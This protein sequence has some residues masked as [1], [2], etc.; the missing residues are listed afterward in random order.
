LT[1]KCFIVMLFGKPIEWIEQYKANVATLRKYGFEWLILTDVE[2][3]KAKVRKALG[4]D[5]CLDPNSTKYWDYRPFLGL[6]LAD[7]LRGFDFWGHTD[8]DVIYGRLDRWVTD[9]L[10]GSVDVFSNDPNACCGFFTLYRNNGV[11]N[12]LCLELNGGAWGQ[13]LETDQVFVSDEVGMT[14]VVRRAW[15]EGRIAWAS[16]F[17][18]GNDTN[19]VG[20]LRMEKDG[21][22]IWNGDEI[23]AY[24]F[25]RTKRWAL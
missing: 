7:E 22:L 19:G 6:I 14:E 8:H 5:P 4:V 3:F 16:R 15:D 10:L 24:H 1:K 20:D 2:D 21:R 23:M 25:R 13:T 18:Q 11:T 12:R 9:D 17:W